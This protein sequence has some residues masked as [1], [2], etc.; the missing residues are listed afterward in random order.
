M[1]NIAG[2]AEEQ[3]NRGD[4][5]APIMPPE[6]VHTGDK[7]PRGPVAACIFTAASRWDVFRLEWQRR[8]VFVRHETAITSHGAA[9]STQRALAGAILV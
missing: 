3:I 9:I 2:D 1:L 5:L 7:P 6:P 8:L 4:W